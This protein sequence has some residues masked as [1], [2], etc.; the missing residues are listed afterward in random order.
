VSVK[1]GP[2]PEFGVPTVLFQTPLTSPSLISAQYL[3]ADNGQRFL[4]AAPAGTT[5]TSIMVVLDWT[6]LLQH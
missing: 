4:L 3:V 2:E 5:M 6:K 1:P